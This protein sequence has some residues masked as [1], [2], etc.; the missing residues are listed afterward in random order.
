LAVL[1]GDGGGPILNDKARPLNSEKTAAVPSPVSLSIDWYHEGEARTVEVDGVRITVRFVGRKE[2]LKPG[3]NE[4][5]EKNVK[6]VCEKI[7]DTGEWPQGCSFFRFYTLKSEGIAYDGL[8]LRL[9]V[10]TPQ[11]RSPS[12]A[13]PVLDLYFGCWQE[14]VRTSE[15]G[16]PPGQ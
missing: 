12:F 3:S 14:P 8:G 16:D 5:F 15:A 7:A 11:A 1:V 13:L 9:S 2:K 4:Y 10:E 6:P